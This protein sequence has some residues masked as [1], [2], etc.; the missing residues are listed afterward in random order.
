MR[1]SYDSIR[2]LAKKAATNGAPRVGTTR[3][4]WDISGDC[5]QPRSRDYWGRPDRD[6]ALEKFSAEVAEWKSNAAAS[7]FANTY[8]EDFE[9]KPLA[10]K[11]VNRWSSWSG[12]EQAIIAVTMTVRCRKC[13]TCLDLRRR[14]W[15]ARA[16]AE[17]ASAAR[18]WFGT[19]TFNPQEQTLA[20]FRARRKAR[21]KSLT[22]ETLTEQQRFIKHHEQLGEL[23]TLWLKRVRKQVG[24]KNLRYLLVCEAHKSGL[25]HY[26]ILVHQVDELRP[27][28][29]KH[30]ARTFPHGFVKF[31]LTDTKQ[32]DWKRRARYPCKYLAK[33]VE[34][35][36]RASTRYGKERSQA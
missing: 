34:A 21:Q 35:R 17:T 2:R 23:I 19:I 4:E 9:F 7:I 12:G 29:W 25:P 28:L 31:N 20:L 6:R 26:H 3:W 11:G 22:W 24:M 5:H 16:L 30:L 36:V 14:Q 18:T 15:A 1:L 10:P 13:E 32:D 8:L 27:I 33:A